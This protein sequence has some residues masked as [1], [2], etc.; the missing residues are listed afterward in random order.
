[1]KKRTFLL[2]LF[3]VA[4]AGA[5]VV[6]AQT[7]TESRHIL[8][9]Y[10][11]ALAGE[12][13][14]PVKCGFPA[15]A[16]LHA[17]PQTDPELAA[18]LQAAVQRPRLDQSYVTP[19]R[20]FRIHYTLA[21]LHAVD[22]TSTIVPNVPDFVYEAGEAA[23][24]AYHLLVDS[25]GFA[26][27]ADDNDVDG[28]EFDFY[29]QNRGNVYGETFLEFSAQQGR[30]PAYIVFDND[31]KGFFSEGLDGLRV[32]V[33]H[34][35]FH[36]VQLNLRF[37]N[38]DVFFYEISSTWFEDVAYDSVNDYL[39]YL[40]NKRS[41]PLGFFQALDL[42]LNTANGWHEYGSCL[43]LHYSVKRIDNQR[44]RYRNNLVYHMWQR[45]TQE[46]ALF[47]M[48]TVLESPPYSMLFNDALREFYEWCFFTGARADAVRYFEEGETYPQIDFTQRTFAVEKDTTISAALR[49]VA[50]HA[51]RLIRTGQNTEFYLQAAEPGRWR[52]TTITNDKQLGYLLRS[53]VGQ[54]P[55][56][57]EAPAGED[58]VVAMVV[59]AN[60]PASPAS[61]PSH[62]YKL[63]VRFVSQQELV[64]LLDKPY[65]NPLRV[66]DGRALVVPFRIR[67]R[68]KVEVA[69]LREDGQVMHHRDLGT[70]PAGN[71]I[72][73]W[74]GLDES[75]RR[76]A[77]GVYFIRLLADD[78]HETTKFVVIN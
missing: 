11:L 57:V 62:D 69:I 8:Q 70:L 18:L 33:A 1:M 36:A 50:A 3:V 19:S 71:H 12:S 63:Q 64:N 5:T 24:W 76:L 21:G 4:C 60:L 44:L 26:P 25:L 31:F 52:V 65:P 14:Q 6:H 40:L 39:A 9:Q 54:T 73:E 58:T 43:W 38:E 27:H 53:G 77:S 67:Q 42:S 74:N 51:Y 16:L 34:E 20:R 49:T 56:Y 23:E 68:M 7:A 48:K 41:A 17:E 75:G 22:P 32:T 61:S 37:R 15:L 59:N 35:Y 78:F 46:P 30:G 66:K 2:S 72:W 13:A 10:R 29:I 47:A 28:P 45:L 55:I